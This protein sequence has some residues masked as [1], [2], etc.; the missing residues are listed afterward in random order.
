MAVCADGAI[1]AAAVA[2]TGAAAAHAARASRLWWR[3]REAACGVVLAG[4]SSGV[5]RLWQLHLSRIVRGLQRLAAYSSHVLAV[6]SEAP[7]SD[8]ASEPPELH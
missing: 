2:A 8:Y 1:A 5:P 4:E 6:N 7:G 3:H